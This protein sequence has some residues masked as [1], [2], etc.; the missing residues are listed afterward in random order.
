MI[1]KA[2]I[3][4]KSENNVNKF[5]IRIPIFETPGLNINQKLNNNIIEATLCYTPGS[6]DSYKEGDCVFITFEN[7]QL[8]RPIILGKLYIGEEEIATTYDFLNKLKV[9]TEADLP[10]NTKIGDITYNDLFQLIQNQKILEDK[11]NDIETNPINQVPSDWNQTDNTKKDYIFNKPQLKVNNENILEGNKEI[12]GSGSVSINYKNNTIEINGKDIK[13]IS[14]KNTD[15]TLEITNDSET[16]TTTIDSKVVQQ[17]TE[18]PKVVDAK[19]NII[20]VLK[21]D[22]GIRGYIYNPSVAGYN[23]ID[24]FDNNIK[25]IKIINGN[26]N[27]NV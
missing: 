15:G 9:I 12:I 17:V 5:Y 2:Y 22:D 11:I 6:L 1:T 14:I 27:E 20:Y 24:N 10:D 16:Y 19:P 13:D 21:N 4:R 8:S 25:K 18:L 3:I 23:V 7:N 26:L